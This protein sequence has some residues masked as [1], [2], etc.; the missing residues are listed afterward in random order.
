MHYVK[1]MPYKEPEPRFLGSGEVCIYCPQCNWHSETASQ[2]H[3]RLHGE[4]KRLEI[5]LTDIEKQ[6]GIAKHEAWRAGCE[7]HS[8]HYKLHQLTGSW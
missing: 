2:K 4:A 5:R 7:A 1:M 8:A 6:L 3:E